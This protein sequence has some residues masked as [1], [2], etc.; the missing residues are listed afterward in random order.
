MSITDRLG[1]VVDGNQSTLPDDA[2]LTALSAL[3]GTPGIVVETAA[4]TF[5]K[6]TLQPPAAGLTIT[7]PAGVAGNPTFALAND[8]A[9][10]E[11]LSS[12]G[13]LSRTATSAYAQRTITGTAN[14]I[15]VTNGDGVAG[16]PTLSLPAA[17]TMTGKTLTGG[18]YAGITITTSTFNGNIWTAGTGTLTLGAG[19][20]AT[21]S[22]T[23]TFTGTDTSSIA[24]GAGGIVAYQG[25]SL[26]QFAATTSLQLKGVISDETGSGAL[27][28]GTSPTLVTPALGTPSAIVLTSA[29]GLPLT[30]GVTGVLPVANGGTNAITAAAARTSLGVSG[31]P[32]GFRVTKNAV[33][34]TGIASN[35]ATTLTWST[36]DFDQG[37]FFTSNTWTPS[38]GLVNIKLRLLL[39][40]TNQIVGNASIVQILKNGTAI[41]NK[42][43]T[44]AGTVVQE[45]ISLEVVDTAGGSDAYTASVTITTNASTATVS[46]ATAYT[47][48]SG[49]V[50]PA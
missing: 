37:N 47:S 24:F 44:S 25:G 46:G 28:F 31:I 6:R 16:N 8:L 9:A 42:V 49:I 4:D 10:L 5:T 33:D 35:V 14:E 39:P 45:S 7:N 36:E 34:Q 38:A 13:I 12:T 18:A 29:T 48:F 22:N 19:K 26:A 27:V 43:H 3:D 50:Y 40:G 1:F 11:A 21:I 32:L 20:T 2:T 15:T 41:A 30:T 23:L 17:L